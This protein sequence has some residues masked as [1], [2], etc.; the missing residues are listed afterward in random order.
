VQAAAGGLLSFGE[1]RSGARAYVAVAGGIDVPPLLGSRA[2]HLGSAMGGHAG[3]PLIAGD[4]LPLGTPRRPPARRTADANSQ[5][6]PLNSAIAPTGAAQATTLQLRV[7]RGPQDDRFSSDALDTLLAAPYLV[8]VDSNRMGYRL[9]G[10]TLRHR[11]GADIISDATP[12]GSIQ[13]PGSGQALLLMADRQTTGG[14]PKLATV[15]SADIGVAAQAA[16]GDRLQFVLC[17]DAEAIRA[18]LARERPLLALESS[19]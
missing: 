15:I 17:S 4:R 5:G 14:Y 13:V 2:T 1:R 9:E 6:E 18:L 19:S 3:R 16:P 12:L 8:S 11:G 7:L 10:V